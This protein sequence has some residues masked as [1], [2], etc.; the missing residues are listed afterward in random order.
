MLYTGNKYT[1]TF[2]I[3]DINI[4]NVIHLKHFY[5][6]PNYTHIHVIPTNIYKK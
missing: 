6:L 2:T 3:V 5:L 1:Q 4:F